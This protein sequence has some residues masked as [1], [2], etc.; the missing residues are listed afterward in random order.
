MEKIEK[1]NHNTVDD[2]NI[3]HCS[4]DAFIDLIHTEL[5]AIDFLFQRQRLMNRSMR[6]H[7]AMTKFIHEN[8]QLES[9]Q[10]TKE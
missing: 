2:K 1:K 8:K 7:Y 10:K 3:E 9:N 6:S 5:V 4:A